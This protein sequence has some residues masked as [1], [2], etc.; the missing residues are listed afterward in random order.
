MNN[1][2]SSLQELSNRQKEAVTYTAGPL[3]VLAGAGSG[4][5][6]VLTHKVAW[7]IAEEIAAPENIMAVTFTN[8]AAGEMR[9]RIDQLVGSDSRKISAGTFHGYGLRFLFR[10]R[11]AAEDFLK[12]REGFTV[13]DRDDSKALLRDILDGM[14]LERDPYETLEIISRDYMLWSPRSPNRRMIDNPE[15]LSVAEEYRN[16]LRE[17][18]AVDF[19]DLMI[20]PLKLLARDQNI[21][22]SEQE[23]IRWLLVDEYQDVNS[24]Q[25]LLLKYLVGRDCTINVV[26][27]PDQS[28]YG[29]RGADIDVIL[30]FEHEFP[31]AKVIRLEENYRSTKNI[32]TASNALIRNNTKRLKKN[33]FTV[34][35]E[36]EKIYTLIAQSGLQEADFLVR[37]IDRLHRVKSYPYRNIAILYRQNSMSRVLEKKFLEND[38]PYRIIRG[39]SFYERMEVK[40]VLSVLKLALNPADIVSLGRIAK[41]SKYILSG[42]GPKSLGLWQ[43]WLNSQLLGV[44][45]NPLQLWTLAASGSWKVRGK[46]GE[47]MRIFADYMT[48]ILD[49]ADEGIRPAVDYVLSDMGYSAYLAENYKDNYADRLDNVRELK[50]IVPDG[51]LRET[52]AEASLFTD[53]DSDLDKDRD[54]VG[55]MTLHASK[56]LEFPVVFIIGLEEDLFPRVSKDSPDPDSELEEERRLCYVGMTRAEERLY[57]TAA[58][59]RLLYGSIK[60]NDLSRFLFEIPDECKRVDDRGSPRSDRSYGGRKYG[61]YSGNR[62][63]RFW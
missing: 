16:R 33:L 37:E 35:N 12:L 21:R 17:L 56:G 25:A 7:L 61:G 58:R 6:R 50:S 52:L 8:K 42:M 32:L 40:D 19:D 41:M 5:T 60:N 28:I 49:L 26:G 27:D 54:A 36:G 46:A 14:E 11:H 38:I 34:K 48:G 18:N 2:L 10:Y 29:W 47:S 51:D 63:Y 30:N 15:L 57:M 31:R 43:D 9:E 24:A 4:K 13:F 3:L 1:T 23:R 59:S 55:L 39:L 22:K 62:G 53:A 44:R 20:L 45:D